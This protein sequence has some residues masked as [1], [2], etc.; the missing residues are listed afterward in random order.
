MA[1]TLVT[2]Y[3]LEDFPGAPFSDSLVDAAV[4]DIRAEAGWHIAPLVNATLQIHSYGGNVLFLPSRRVTAV[5]AVR[6]MSNGGALVT[7]WQQVSSELWRWPYGYGY[8][9]GY[10][11]Y[12]YGWPVG[13]VEVDVTHG[14]DATPVDLLPVVAA[15]ALLM[16]NPRDP[17]LTERLVGQVAEKYA[18]TGAARPADPVVSRYALPSGIV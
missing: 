13:I 5:T 1:N 8:G 12:Y 15:R 3:D 18:S 7:G 16:S 14:Y 2:A 11:G 10:G 9:Y 6:N 4:A 17:A